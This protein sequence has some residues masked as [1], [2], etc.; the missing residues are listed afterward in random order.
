L[1]GHFDESGK[2]GQHPI[3][4]LSGL[5]GDFVRWQ[6]LT[7]DWTRLLREYELPVLHAT[8]ILSP[9]TR[10]GK[11]G[12]AATHE[13][14]TAQVE[15]FIKSVVHKLNGVA[16][17]VAVDVDAYSR[18]RELH[19][20]FTRDPHYFAF[21]MVVNN[22]LT[23]CSIPRRHTVGLIFDDEQEKALRSY[24]LL[25]RM[26][27]Q[28]P[29][30]TSRVTSICFSDD[31]DAPQVQAADLF[32]CLSRLEAM[33][34]FADAP[35]PYESLFRAFGAVMPTGEHLCMDARFFSA[36]TLRTFAQTGKAG[37]IVF[38]RRINLPR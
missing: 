15:P 11:L 7:A 9:A 27:R 14:R 34:I 17:A 3:V 37:E 19:R 5:V 2:Y 25:K 6:A 31:R 21:F 35:Y 38:A 12:S 32:A 26:K 20:D 23:H 16:I 30:V 18:V 8:E 4:S 36:E 13:E 33:K 29:E 24:R 1:Y 22:L 28:I 10:F